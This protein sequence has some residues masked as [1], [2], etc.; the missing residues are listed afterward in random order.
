MFLQKVP[1]FGGVSLSRLV[2]VAEKIKTETYPTQARII[3]QGEEGDAFYVISEG[4]VDVV[5]DEGTPAAQV[6]A[7]LKP[8]EFFGEV[9]L[10]E[11]HGR[12]TA[13]VI[14]TEPVRLYVLHKADFQEALASSE[15]MKEELVKVFSQRY[16]VLRH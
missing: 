8:G 14:A 2:S 9:A 1:L 7:S 4:K 10:I 16:R 12:R 11:E 5:A 15:T 3:R 6:K 13:T